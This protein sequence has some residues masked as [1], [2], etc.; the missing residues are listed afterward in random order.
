MTGEV[1]ILAVWG[2]SFWVAFLVGL[3]KGRGLFGFLLG[4]STGPVG[5]F[6]MLVFPSAV[7]VCIACQKNIPSKAVKCPY[8]QTSLVQAHGV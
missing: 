4:L 8:C 3:V 1:F 6:V 2:V 5:A 7:K